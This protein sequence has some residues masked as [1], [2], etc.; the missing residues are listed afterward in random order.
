MHVVRLYTIRKV[1]HMVYN[2]FVKQEKVG[3]QLL[4]KAEV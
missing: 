3:H 2:M 4:E 1:I